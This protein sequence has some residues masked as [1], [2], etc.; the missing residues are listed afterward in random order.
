MYK[1]ISTLTGFMR[2]EILPNPFEFVSDNPIIVLLFTA[3]IGSKLLHKIAYSMC[4]MIYS[5]GNPT[6]GSIL[7]MLFYSTNVGVLVKLS[8]IFNNMQVVCTVY[9]VVLLGI[10][11][12]L[13]RISCLY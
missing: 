2:E 10:Y 1:I 13:N 6:L 12:L 9:V 7:Y 5:G 11:A 3:C 8:S 4:G